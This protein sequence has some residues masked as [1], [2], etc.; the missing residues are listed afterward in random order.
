MM[1]WTLK[2]E[3]T[4]TCNGFRL[5]LRQI[6]QMFLIGFQGLTLSQEVRDLIEHY[7]IGN[8][9]FARRNITGLISPSLLSAD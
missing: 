8:I 5:I 1:N 3:S 4:P 7:F 9:I 6:G 2:R